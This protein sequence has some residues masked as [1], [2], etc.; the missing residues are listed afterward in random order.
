MNYYGQALDILK[1]NGYDI[2][3]LT[4]EETMNTGA[5]GTHAQTIES[6]LVAIKTRALFSL[7]WVNG[8]YSLP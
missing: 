4:Q 2:D 3:S 7:N 6:V 8:R 5:S 1:E